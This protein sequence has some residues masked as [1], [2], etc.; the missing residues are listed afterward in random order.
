MNENPAPARKSRTEAKTE[1]QVCIDYGS[2]TLARQS[3]GQ[4]W[5]FPYIATTHYWVRQFAQVRIDDGLE[6]QPSFMIAG[7]ENVRK[8][9]ARSSTKQYSPKQKYHQQ[10][11][12]RYS[13]S[14][15]V[16]GRWRPTLDQRSKVL[17]A[18]MTKVFMKLNSV[19]S[20][21]YLD[22][23]VALFI[24]LNTCGNQSSQPHSTRTF[25]T[26]SVHIGDDKTY[27]LHRLSQA[28]KLLSCMN[29]NVTFHLS[30]LMTRG[31]VHGHVGPKRYP[32]PQRFLWMRVPIFVADCMDH[33]IYHFNHTRRRWTW[34]FGIG[35]ISSLSTGRRTTAPHEPWSY[36]V[37]RSNWR[38]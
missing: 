14:E 5:A 26:G 9:H 8:S 16:C 13:S 32:Q 31:S 21:E 22:A 30:V 10:M 1:S 36:S 19:Q 11:L 3:I 29:S 15:I 18:F 37:W 27:N 38:C 4:L 35:P 33:L 24:A 25:T 6:W 2:F 28:L 17:L 20:L 12:E 23:A 7:R 34:Y